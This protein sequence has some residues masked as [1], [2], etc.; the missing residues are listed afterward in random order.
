MYKSLRPDRIAA[1]CDG[2][3]TFGG[4]G[5]RQGAPGASTGTGTVS[6]QATAH[7]ERIEWEEARNRRASLVWRPRLLFGGAGTAAG[8]ARAGPRPR[9]AR[10]GLRSIVDR[11]P[12]PMRNASA[13]DTEPL[14]SGIKDTPAVGP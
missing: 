6:Y 5:A 12:T 7:P 3:A 14:G 4:A 11:P 9:I 2:R 10:C 1:F 13:D 8:S